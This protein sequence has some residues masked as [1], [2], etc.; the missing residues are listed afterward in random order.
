MAGT[1]HTPRSMEPP[2]GS[3]EF[4]TLIADLS[5]K[6][7]NLPPDEVDGGIRDAL[8]GVCEFLAID[9]AVLWQWSVAAQDVIA[10]THAYPS[11]NGSPF[12]GPL[13]Q[14]QYPWTIRQMR[15]GHVIV[16]P[17]LDGLTA[18][19][20]VDRESARLIGI[21]STLC[22]PLS[23][24][25]ESPVG[26]LAF[27]ALRARRDWPDALVSRL[28]LVAQVFANAL[29]RKR[30]DEALRESEERLSLAADAA[31]AGLW[32]LDYETGVFWATGRTRT[33]FGFPPD[34]VVTL[35]R[36]QA[37]VHPDDRLLVRDAIERS[38]QSGEPA[39]VECRIREGGGDYRW[40]SN[41]GRSHAG[42]RGEPLRVMGVS[43]DVSER[44][45]EHESLLAS[46][47]R[48]ASG[49]ELA[50]L[51]FYDVDFR[52]A[53]MYSDD[54]LRDLC[55][56]P[57]DRVDGLGVLEFWLE[58]LHPDDRPHVVELRRQLH[59]GEQDRF[60]HE[61][62]Y[63]HPDRG[64]QWIQH[65]AGVAER[66]QSGR[67]TRTYGVLRDVTDRKRAEERSRDLS[68]RLIRAQEEERV[69]LARELHDDVSQRLAVLAIDVGRAELAA[70]D[71]AQA[72]A[73]QTVREELV[74]LSDDVHSLAYQLHPSVLEELGL[75]EALRAE[76]GRRSRQAHLDIA[77]DLDPLPPAIQAD[78][79]LCLFRVAQE[80]LNNVAHH[81]DARAA[82]VAL[83]RRGDGLLLV[84]SDN[85]GGFELEHHEEGMHLG[86][87]G[88]RERARLASGTLD[89][90]SAPGCGTK[91]IAWVPL[92][93]AP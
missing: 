27:N 83:R 38:A 74:S 55:G 9:Y 93:A 69:L 48:L 65:L 92:K 52:A 25:G 26:A 76:C 16:L 68:R 57:P 32:M 40:V 88:M 8:R 85:G 58:C 77:M 67:A 10:P 63:L 75:A 21:Q 56:V 51:G 30:N 13:R 53:V 28:Q 36:V 73:M 41:R 22:L 79:A 64:E 45:L 44:R 17:S 2:G 12:P 7:I 23:V 31:E 54:R 47:A 35:E 1:E 71:E 29:A 3:L 6:F 60:S 18:E 59:E 39:N 46:E 61:Y 33:I 19:A 91:V 4:E 90:E 89:I 11:E 42:L 50:G 66:D 34:E 81:A 24:G 87:S 14:E 49:A 62:R 72:E 43:V 15:A 37:R 70:A 86:I 84:V 5:S 80:A 20:A 82:T 78:T